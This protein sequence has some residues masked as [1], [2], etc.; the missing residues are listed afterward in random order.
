MKF[1]L[2]PGHKDTKFQREWILDFWTILVPI[3]FLMKYPVYLIA[4]ALLLSSCASIMNGSHSKTTFYATGPVRV[5]HDGDTLKTYE[6]K[7]ELFLR[8]QKKN[9][10]IT[11]LT[12]TSV[13]AI[14][15]K[16]HGSVA[17]GLNY[18]A[19]FGIGFLFDWKKDKR[20]GYCRKVYI[21]SKKRS[22]FIPETNP[23]GGWDIHISLPH[24]NA[25]SFRP[26]GEA[27]KN[28]AG[29]LGLAAGLD[30]YYKQDRFLSLQSGLTT[31]FFL[32]FPAAHDPNG[33]Y[34]G[35]ASL[36][37]T[38]SNNYNIKRFTLGY[39]LSVARNIWSYA[40]YDWSG[41]NPVPVRT[42]AVNRKWTA[43]GLVFPAYFKTGRHFRIGLI[44]RP[45]F[46]RPDSEEKFLY[47]HLISLDLAWKIRL[48]RT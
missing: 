35:L 30:Y 24:A 1:L 44:Y 46:Y 8:R 20:Y 11:I 9:I 32:P 23:A 18:I 12:D 34:E 28:H 19:N 16:P 36:S 47:E 40:Y 39:G 43:L 7:L 29:F 45:T 33:A 4:L 21:G 31:D 38:L 22:D 15:L 5:V 17:F 41:V 10:P 6:N 48:N 14:T 25:F 3:S 2:P 13:K 27:T 42:N 37:F 26:E